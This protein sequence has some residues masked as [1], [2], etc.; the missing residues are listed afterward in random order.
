MN[1]ALDGNPQ[2]SYAFAGTYTTYGQF[3][4]NVKQT[5]AGI[6]IDN[7]SASV[8]AIPEPASVSLL[9]LGALAMLRRGRSRL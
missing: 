6:A 8:T 7:V 5:S 2:G 3:K 4:F 1:I 9:T